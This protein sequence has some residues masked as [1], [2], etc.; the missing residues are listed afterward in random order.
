[1]RMLKR[2]SLLQ[3]SEGAA[4]REGH[5]LAADETITAS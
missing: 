4:G 3:R 5:A 1:M 2:D